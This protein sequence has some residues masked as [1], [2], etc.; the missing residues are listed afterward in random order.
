MNLLKTIASNILRGWKTTLLG[1]V[2]FT[3]TI[4]SVFR[5]EGVTWMDAALPILFSVALLLTPRQAKGAIRDFIQKRT[6]HLCLL[7]CLVACNKKAIPADSVAATT[8]VESI[9]THTIAADSAIL[10]LEHVETGKVYTHTSTRAKATVTRD[11]KGHLRFV[12]DCKPEIIRD[13][14]RLKVDS[15][16]KIPCTHTPVQAKKKDSPSGW[17]WRNVLW[18]FALLLCGLI[19]FAWSFLYLQKLAKTLFKRE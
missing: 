9:H 3:A 11:A 15:V 12:A 8:T 14:V 19:I 5:V 4:V 10:R 18:P 6:I 16:V 1:L 17:L 7:L 13:T 2:L